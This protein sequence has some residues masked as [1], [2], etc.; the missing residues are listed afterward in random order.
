MEPA[1][2]PLVSVV[3][4]CYN[5]QTH[6]AEAMQSVL[7]QTYP[8]VEY[9]VIDGGSTDSTMDIVRS[10]AEQ[11][12]G[13]LRWV[14]EP[15]HGIY[16]AMN[17]GIELS[18]GELIGLLNSDDA[19]VPDALERIVVAFRAQPDAG[20][21]FGDVEVVSQDGTPLRTEVA[22]TPAPGTLPLRMPMCHQSLFVARRVY[23][24]LGGFDTDHRILA[25]Y[26]HVLRMLRAGERFVHVPGVVA[27]FREGGACSADTARSNAERERIRVAYGANPVAERARRIRHAVNRFV[28]AL[29]RR[30]AP[31]AHPSDQGGESG[32]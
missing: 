29:V 16:D 4:V 2:G 13:R 31:S 11:F 26:E 9:L 28:Y 18:T 14:S 23:R 7:D 6:I 22:V 3:T 5:S 27:R 12:G 19:Y 20:A 10:F 24:E 25:D 17:K 8:H 30:P 21:V 32:S 15:D 1:G